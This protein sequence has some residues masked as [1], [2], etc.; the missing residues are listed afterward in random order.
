[1]EGLDHYGFI[2]RSQ[3]LYET[4]IASSHDEC[5]QT[6]NQFAIADFRPWPP[7]AD[8][9]VLTARPASTSGEPTTPTPDCPFNIEFTGW[10]RVEAILDFGPHPAKLLT[11]ALLMPDCGDDGG[12]AAAIPALAYLRCNELLEGGWESYG[13]DWRRQLSIEDRRKPADQVIGAAKRCGIG[14]A[15]CHTVPN[16]KCHRW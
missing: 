8:K 15:S 13:G 6:R 2:G 10:S 9:A 4:C 16:S 12:L 5:P 3:A 7:A 1:V 14:R 11:A